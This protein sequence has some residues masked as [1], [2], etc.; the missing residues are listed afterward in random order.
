[1]PPLRGLAKKQADLLAWCPDEYRAEY[2]AL[3]D[4]HFSPEEARRIIEDHIAVMQR[5]ASA[6]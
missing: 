1:M 3:R 5:R 2:L 6:A 4:K